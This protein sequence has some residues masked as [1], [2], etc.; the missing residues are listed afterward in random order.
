M[1]K[2]REWV[3]KKTQ[4]EGF[5]FKIMEE[6]I[7][8]YFRIANINRLFSK[9]R[10]KKYFNKNK[11]IK[12]QFG[13]GDKKLYGFLNT[14]ILGEIP[15]N[16]TKK[17]PFKDNSVDLIYSNHVIEHIY[18]KQ[19]RRFLEESFRCLKKGGMHIISTP[20]ITKLM[21]SLYLNKKTKRKLI[22]FYGKEKGYGS[23]RVINSLM[24]MCFM[25]KFIY[26]LEIIQILG[27]KV[28]FSKIFSVNNK[29]KSQKR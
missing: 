13:S 17:L 28:G 19:F 14:D 18:Y 11:S 26:D 15:I 5:F 9:K 27:K 29:K 1:G 25:H 3:S 2:I 10:I 24:H 6:L 22:K 12:I 4:G 23:A 20:S 8:F 16:I 7:L 21:K